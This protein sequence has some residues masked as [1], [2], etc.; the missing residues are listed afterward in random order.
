MP[1]KNNA[2]VVVRFFSQNEINPLDLNYQDKVGL[3][4]TLNKEFNIDLINDELNKYSIPF[5]LSDE[6]KYDLIFDE[7]IPVKINNIS[8]NSFYDYIILIIFNLSFTK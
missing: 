8:T 7:Y 6:D 3:K 1:Q 4:I 5:H 2:D